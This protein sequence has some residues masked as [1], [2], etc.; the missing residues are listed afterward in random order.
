[1]HT[2]FFCQCQRT[3]PVVLSGIKSQAPI[4]YAIRHWLLFLHSLKYFINSHCLSNILNDDMRFGM[5]S[6]D[7]RLG[8]VRH[9][10]LC[11]MIHVF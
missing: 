9:S 6:M 7:I 8:L 2:M 3:F 4:F 1:M 5:L 10:E 11:N